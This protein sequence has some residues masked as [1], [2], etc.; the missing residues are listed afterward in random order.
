MD[1]NERR[2]DQLG[3]PHGTASNRLKKIIMFNLL[4]RLGEDFCFQCGAKIESSEELSIE[5]KIPWLDNSTE[6]FWD[7]N[8]ISFSHRSC[9]SGAGRRKESPHGA[10]RCYK[11]GCRCAECIEGNTRRV[12]ETRARRKER[13]SILS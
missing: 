6:L 7:I 13:E 5:H 3:M 12:R 11:K 2:H 1:T 9:N 8:N 10:E 4:V